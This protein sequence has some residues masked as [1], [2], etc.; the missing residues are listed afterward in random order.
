MDSTDLD[1][2]PLDTAPVDDLD[3]C[4]MGWDPLGGVPVHDIDGVPLGA[5]I[6]NIDGIPC[7]S[8]TY[9]KHDCPVPVV[10]Y[11]FNSSVLVQYTDPLFYVANV[12]VDL[13]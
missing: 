2:L 7:E 12:N 4:P 9:W 5:T 10:N 11:M 8:T 1:G 13:D 3:G 6:D